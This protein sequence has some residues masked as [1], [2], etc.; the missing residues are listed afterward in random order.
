MK[1]GEGGGGGGVS[2]CWREIEACLG[3]RSHFGRKEQM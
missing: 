2:L 3:K 1:Q